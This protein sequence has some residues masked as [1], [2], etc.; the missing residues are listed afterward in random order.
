MLNLE[1]GPLPTLEDHVSPGTSR[2]EHLHPTRTAHADSARSECSSATADDGERKWPQ[3]W[4]EGVHFLTIDTNRLFVAIPLTICAKTSCSHT[5][6]SPSGLRVTI[7]FGRRN[8][9]SLN[10][11]PIR[12]TPLLDSDKPQ[13]HVALS[14]QDRC[15]SAGADDYHRPFRILIHIVDALTRNVGIYQR[16]RRSATR[17][18][19]NFPGGTSGR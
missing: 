6:F 11:R 10:L 7:Q 19:G 16:Q 8:R 9:S 14:G 13:P 4:S 2:Q 1:S 15:L 17:A 3:H 18:L 12:T 5:Q